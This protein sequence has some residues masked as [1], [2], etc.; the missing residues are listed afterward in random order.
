MSNLAYIVERLKK[1]CGFKYFRSSSEYVLHIV[2]KK[3][4]GEDIHCVSLWNKSNDP[5]VKDWTIMSELQSGS[6]CR[7]FELSFKAYELFREFIYAMQMKED[8]IHE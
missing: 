5:K 4:I 6:S 3:E 7:P 2:F 8:D 1:E